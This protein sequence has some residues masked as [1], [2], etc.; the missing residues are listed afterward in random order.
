[1]VLYPQNGG[2]ILGSQFEDACDCP[3]EGVN[4]TLTTKGHM[5]H[6]KKREGVYDAKLNAY[7]QPEEIS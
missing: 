5:M 6:Q 2:Q 7:N 3:A 4:W 1:M